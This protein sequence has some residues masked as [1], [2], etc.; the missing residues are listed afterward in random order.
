[1]KPWSH[2]AG[3]VQEGTADNGLIGNFPV[4]GTLSLLLWSCLARRVWRG[5]APAR[6]SVASTTSATASTGAR[7]S[8]SAASSNPSAGRRARRA[9]P[10]GRKLGDGESREIIPPRSSIARAD[11]RAWPSARTFSLSGIS[12]SNRSARTILAGRGDTSALFRRNA[13]FVGLCSASRR[14]RRSQKARLPLAT[15]AGWQP[16]HERAATSPPDA[17]DRTR[18]S[19]ICA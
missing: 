17:G 12:L 1:M 13:K 5:A 6:T 14:G 9:S 11:A 8:R 2:T 3:K 10:R 18:A 16:R 19:S 15:A 7:R 4:E